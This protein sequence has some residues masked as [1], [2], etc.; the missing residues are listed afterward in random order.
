MSKVASS[1][2]F[3][4]KRYVTRG[5]IVPEGTF[6]WS[7]MDCFG[8][9]WDLRSFDNLLHIKTNVFSFS[10]PYMGNINI[11]I[12]QKGH[13][14]CSLIVS[15]CW[16]EVNSNYQQRNIGVISAYNNLIERVIVFNFLVFC[17]RLN[18]GW[19]EAF[20]QTRKRLIIPLLYSLINHW[21]CK[22]YCMRIEI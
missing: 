5:F 16:L 21:K 11:S 1:I 13:Y 8:Q 15:L 18:D 22:T 14:F 2:S 4:F 9:S 6:S 20:N 19:S 12:T 3:N 10:K 17:R 7:C